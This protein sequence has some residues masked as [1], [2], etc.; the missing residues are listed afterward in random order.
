MR[1][2]DGR[3][4]LYMPVLSDL[5]QVLLPAIGA[6]GTLTLPAVAGCFHAI[7]FC[8]LSYT[9]NAA[10]ALGNAAVTTTNL[11]GTALNVQTGAV[12]FQ[13]RLYELFS[14]SVPHRSD[15]VGVAS[16]IVLPAAPAGGRW[17]LVVHYAL[18]NT[19]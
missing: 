7:T 3:Q 2:Q 11:G 13:Q 6:G 12:A 18:L 16:T 8:L 9:A 17:E 4:G 10:I 5:T 14:R 15:V 19:T 1:I